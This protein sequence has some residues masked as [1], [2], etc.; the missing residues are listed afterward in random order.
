ML[1]CSIRKFGFCTATSPFRERSGTAR[2]GADCRLLTESKVFSSAP[3]QTKK[4]FHPSGSG[5]WF[6]TYLERTKRRFAYRLA[7][8]MY[9]KTEIRL[10]IAF[11]IKL[12]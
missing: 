10:Q 5:S 9:W 7:N 8:K 12:K 4:A 6:Q 11:A 1:G 2:K 3:V